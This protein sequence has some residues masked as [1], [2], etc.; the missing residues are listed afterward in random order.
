[1]EISSEIKKDKSVSTTGGWLFKLCYVVGILIFI[2]ATLIVFF[3]NSWKNGLILAGATVLFLILG[4]IS[5]SLGD[6]FRKFVMPSAY[7]TLG[8]TDAFKKRIFWQVGP[9]W[10]SFSITFLVLIIIPFAYINDPSYGA[11]KVAPAPLAPATEAPQTSA[12]ATQSMAPPVAAVTTPPLAPASEAAPVTPPPQVSAPVEKLESTPTGAPSLPT[13]F[14]IDAPSESRALLTS[15]LANPMSAIKLAEAKGEV[16]KIAK[17]TTG[18]RK[19]ARALNEKGLQALNA[20]RYSEASSFLQQAVAVDP[21][22][23]EIRNNYVYALLKSKNI[24]VAEKEVGTTLTFSPGRSSAWANLA[25]I[26]AEKANV[27]LSTAA[28]I[29]AFQFSSNKDKTLTY[30]KDKAESNENP[31]FSEAAKLALKRLTDG[32]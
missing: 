10:S 17:P 13:G 29:V 1:M 3:N 9:Q 6:S 20:D 8:T 31:A 16:E 27:Q 28:L 22:D 7:L 19:G 23:I 30:L 12:L 5:W 14:S 24:G 4:P 32:Q 15:M 18:D 25:E 26:Y 11:A 2:V 21:A